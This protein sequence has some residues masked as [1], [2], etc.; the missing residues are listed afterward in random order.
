MAY[1]VGQVAK[2]ARVSIRALHH[3]DHI[4]LLRPSSR[5][6]A[7]YRLYGESDLLRLQ[8]I[9]FFEELD[10]PLRQIQ[11]TLDDPVFDH[12]EALE[13]HRRLLRK[14]AER[15]ARLLMTVDKTNQRL[16]EDGVELTDG[17]LYEGFAQEQV[18]RYEREARE[19]Y[20]PELVKE[21]ERR[22][23]KM[24]KTQWEG[25]KREG[26]EVTRLIA[27]LIDKP[28]G[29]P[30]VQTLIGQHHG[31]IERFYDAPAEV[32][33]GLGELYAEHDDFRDYYNKYRAGLADYMRAA[34]AYYADHVLSVE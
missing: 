21:S 2:T 32:Y 34:M 28:A 12:L 15:L 4:G 9:L 14:Q 5:T 13:N 7:G 19:L 31:W 8:Q 20:D 16:R 10:S 1:T 22:I 17:D 29:D 30:E 18:E 3:Y 24:S 27:G 25:L 23:R 33:R 6:A 26:E 11:D